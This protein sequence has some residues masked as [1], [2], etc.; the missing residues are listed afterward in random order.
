MYKNKNQKKSS[1][2]TTC[3]TFR[4]YCSVV[5]FIRIIIEFDRL[6]VETLNAATRFARVSNEEKEEEAHCAFC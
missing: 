4:L 2:T 3:N 6:D 5:D 1:T